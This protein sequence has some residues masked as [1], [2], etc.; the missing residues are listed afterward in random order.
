M[1]RRRWR[2]LLRINPGL[3]EIRLGARCVP[4]RISAFSEA[5]RCAGS[6]RCNLHPILAAACHP[7]SS[8][9]SN[10]SRSSRFLEGER[11]FID[12]RALINSPAP[13]PAS[14]PVSSS[15]TRPHLSSSLR[16]G[17]ETERAEVNLEARTLPARPKVAL[18]PGTPSAAA[19]RLESRALPE[20]TLTGRWCVP[21]RALPPVAG[22]TVERSGFSSRFGRPPGAADGF[23]VA[24][25]CE[26]SRAARA[27]IA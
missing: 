5:I 19:Q 25:R 18:R 20:P 2:C 12:N 11:R 27:P 13:E 7:Q 22:A 4:K 24:Q 14:W 1:N 3:F 21:N 6:R 23:D 16:P 10:P 8:S 9:W 17:A 26:S 15:S